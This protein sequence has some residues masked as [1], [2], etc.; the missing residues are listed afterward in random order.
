VEYEQGGEMKSAKGNVVLATGGYGADFG[1]D[2]LLAQ[3][4]G[5]VSVD[6]TFPDMMKLST[7]NG[8]HCTGD[9]IKMALGVGAETVDM[10]WVQV[11]PTGLVHP[12][13]PTAKVKFLAAEA[14][15]GCGALILDK[16]GK[17]IANELGRRDYV[18]CRMWKSQGPFRLV[19]NS[20]ASAEIAWHVKHYKSRKVMKAFK[21]GA[22]LA[23]EMGLAPDALDATFKEYNELAEKMAKRKDPNEGP[24]KA[25]G[26]G[27]S[28]DPWGK[29]FFHNY[30]FEI[31]DQF[32][33]AI[34]E[35]CI[36]YC[37]GGVK[38]DKNA[39]VHGKSGPIDGLFGAGEVNGGIHG[40]NRLGG[41]SL[42]D[43]VAYGRVAGRS[44]SKK[45]LMDASGLAAKL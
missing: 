7:T 36:H 14:L 5:K 23:K 1:A 12:D 29:K 21:S 19:L 25:Y 10:N 34:I 4:N 2:S 32:N 33:V 44:A 6:G 41:S 17:R 8:D 16:N 24:Y 35:P 13:E 18:S 28:Y 42:L 43:C 30:P 40:E 26:G 37:M 45:A 31:A 3:V 27:M 15:R 11:H 38:V 20:K 22:D 39:Q 9:G